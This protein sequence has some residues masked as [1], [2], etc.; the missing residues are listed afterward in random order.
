MLM[1]KALTTRMMIQVPDHH[2]VL[3]DILL[4]DQLGAYATWVSS[5][6]LELNLA[7]AN[8]MTAMQRRTHRKQAPDARQCHAILVHAEQGLLSVVNHLRVSMQEV[9]AERLDAC[10]HG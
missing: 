10:V 8:T 3:P 4:L 1:I 6:L 7:Q 9:R 5:R 2:H